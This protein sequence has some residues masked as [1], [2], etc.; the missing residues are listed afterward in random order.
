MSALPN[1]LAFSVTLSMLDACVLL[2]RMRGLVTAAS[3]LSLRDRVA[4]DVSGAPHIQAYVADY[5]GAVLAMDGAALDAVLAGQSADT[6]AALPAA[7]IALPD[8]APLLAGHCLR[9]ARRGVL[10]QVFM[11]EA[12]AVAWAQ[13]EASLVRQ[14]LTHLR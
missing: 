9:M 4:R 5:R 7:M 10:R 13:L 1:G 12:P 3:I 8:T 2:V 11:T 6:G 14:H